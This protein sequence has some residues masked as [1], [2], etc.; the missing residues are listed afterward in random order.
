[1]PS[2]VYHYVITRTVILP[3]RRGS[4]VFINL[5]F[6]M[7]QTLLFQHHNVYYPDVISNSKLS[8]LEH[9]LSPILY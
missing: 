2:P 5:Y 9:P 6:L 8:V 3:I 1:M 7:R 4:G